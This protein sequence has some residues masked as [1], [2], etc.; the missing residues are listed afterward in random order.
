M[1]LLY[2]P[3]LFKCKSLEGNRV[4]NRRKMAGVEGLTVGR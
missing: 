2:F 3:L 4:E 1:I